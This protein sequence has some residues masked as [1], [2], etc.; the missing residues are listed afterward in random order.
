MGVAAVVP[1]LDG[2]VDPLF[3]VFTLSGVVSSVGARLLLFDPVEPVGAQAVNSILK[4]TKIEINF[5]IF[6][7]ITGRI[8]RF[9]LRGSCSFLCKKIDVNE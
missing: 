1:E 8:T 7:R 6:N 5:K 9:L 4:T 3:E 2:V